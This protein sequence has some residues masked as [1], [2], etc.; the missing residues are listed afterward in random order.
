MKKTLQEIKD[1]VAVNFGFSNWHELYNSEVIGNT[2][3]DEVAKQYA[4]EVAKTTLKNFKKNLPDDFEMSQSS[5][6]VFKKTLKNENN[7]PEL[8]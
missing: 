3:V 5:W 4:I 1:Q 6:V 2:V 7:T 8:I